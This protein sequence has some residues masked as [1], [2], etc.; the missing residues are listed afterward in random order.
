MTKGISRR[1]F[2]KRGASTVAVGL[3]VPKLLLGQTGGASRRPADSA[4]KIFVVIQLAGGNDGLNTVIPYTDGNYAAERPNLG[5]KDS[6]LKDSG[7]KSTIISDRFGL[8]PSMSDMKSL[9]DAGRVALVLGVGYPEPNLSHFFSMDVWHTADPTALAGEGWL[10]R[11]ADAAL[12]NQPGLTAAAVSNVLPKSLLSP[13]VVVPSILSF[14]FYDFLT[15]PFHPEDSQDQLGTYRA[16]ASRTLASGSLG[17]T[18]NQIGQDAVSNA[19][20]VKDSVSHYSSPVV[21]PDDNPLAQGLKMAAEIVATIPEANLLY[22]SLGSFD[23]H[24]SEIDDTGGTPNKLSGQHATLLGWFSQAVKLFYDDMAAHSLADNVVMMQWSEFGRRVNENSSLGTDHG[25][26]SPMFVIG[27]P[28]HGGLY[29][30]QP[31]LASSDLD[32]AGNMK[33]AVDFR[34]VY[35]TILDHWLSVDSASILGSSFGDVGFFG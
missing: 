21:Y 11:Y 9:Y 16:N 19:L 5:F 25:T 2:I 34:S 14:Q 6:D 18:I 35:A 31:S 3:F 13:K 10:G 1:Q 24:S 20:Q 8:H 29:G 26:A 30:S 15:D 4:R 22:V 28:I 17:A 27:N 12:I 23:H 32:E 7:G 33:F